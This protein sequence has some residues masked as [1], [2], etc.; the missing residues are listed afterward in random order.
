M[1][2]KTL[3]FTYNIMLC[4][5]AETENIKKIKNESIILNL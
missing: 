1:L 2:P 3:N 5:G 4:F